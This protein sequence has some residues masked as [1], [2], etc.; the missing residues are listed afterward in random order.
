VWSETVV[1]VVRDSGQCGQR[2]WS[3]WSECR[4]SCK[5]DD[6]TDRQSRSRQCNNPLPAN[7]GQNCAE[8][9]TESQ[10]CPDIPCPG[11]SI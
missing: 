5:T 7:G 6:A 2:Q 8:P 11:T 9:S 1:S 10:P 3:V 4:P